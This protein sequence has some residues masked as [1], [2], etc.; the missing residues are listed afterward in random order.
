MAWGAPGAPASCRRMAS[1]QRRLLT[2]QASVG[3]ASSQKFTDT[4][5]GC[6]F[7]MKSPISRRFSARLS[8]PPK[9]S[10]RRWRSTRASCSTVWLSSIC[11]SWNWWY[12]RRIRSGS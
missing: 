10:S 3:K 4:T 12:S 7:W 2:K 11:R 6:S 5:K 1:R 9:R 8:P